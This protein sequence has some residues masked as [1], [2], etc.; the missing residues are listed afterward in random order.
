M[1]NELSLNFKVLV[2]DSSPRSRLSRWP[3]TK[4]L[5]FRPRLQ[6]DGRVVIP[7]FQTYSWGKCS[8]VRHSMVPPGGEIDVDQKDA[9]HSFVFAGISHRSTSTRPGAG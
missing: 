3:G 7:D 5:D 9:A 6:L 8:P 2:Q 1:D 4:N